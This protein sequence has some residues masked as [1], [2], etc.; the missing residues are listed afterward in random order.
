MEEGKLDQAKL[1]VDELRQLKDYEKMARDLDN[2]QRQVLDPASGPLTPVA[3]LRI[4][5]MFQQTRELLQK[6]L[7]N[8]LVQKVEKELDAR[9]KGTPLPTADAEKK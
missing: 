6:Y 1:L 4:E 8:D 2:V 5:K 9:L 3:Q 7:Q